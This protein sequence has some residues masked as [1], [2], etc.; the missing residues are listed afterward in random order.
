MMLMLMLMLML[1]LIL[2]LILIFRTLFT[3]FVLLLPMFTYGDGFTRGVFQL[4]NAELN[5]QYEFI[6]EYPISKKLR[7]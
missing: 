2:I 5:N 7:V 4:S 6:A 3:R 1:I